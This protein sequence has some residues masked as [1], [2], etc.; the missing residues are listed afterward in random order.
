VPL[1]VLFL[2]FAVSC[3]TAASSGTV[4]ERAVCS[5]PLPGPARPARSRPA[6]AAHSRRRRATQRSHCRSSS[7]SRALGL[8]ASSAR[9]N[10][11]DLALAAYNAGP[12]A[13]AQAGGAPSGQTVTY[14]ANVT[15]AWRS[16]R[17][18]T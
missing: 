6:N 16:V 9:K 14:V 1:R 3:R 11:A 17:G 15:E 13:V 10:S 12:S 5:G 18:C 4:V 8:E 2:A 7:P